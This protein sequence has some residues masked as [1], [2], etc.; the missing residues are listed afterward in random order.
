MRALQ[1]VKARVALESTKC[2]VIIKYWWPG[3][4]TLDVEIPKDLH[5]V[6]KNLGAAVLVALKN[7]E[8]LQCAILQGA[9]LRGANLQGADLLGAVIS[10]ANKTYA[11][12]RGAIV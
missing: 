3:N 6:K 9:D 7:K 8:D 10:E 11:K 4:E 1:V 2:V 12:E 5:D